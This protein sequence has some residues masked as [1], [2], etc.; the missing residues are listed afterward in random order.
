MSSDQSSIPDD[1]DLDRLAAEIASDF[2]AQHAGRR[3]EIAEGIAEAKRQGLTWGYI[4]IGGSRVA[5]PEEARQLRDN[6]TPIMRQTA[7]ELRAKKE[8]GSLTSDEESKLQ[9]AEAWLQGPTS[10]PADRLIEGGST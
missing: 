1:P 5:T 9:A 2:A 10:D 3:A 6:W 4:P 7:Q 8:A